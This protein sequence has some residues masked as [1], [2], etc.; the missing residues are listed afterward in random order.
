MALPFHLNGHSMDEKESRLQPFLSPPIAVLLT[1][2]GKLST[3]REKPAHSSQVIY[4]FWIGTR[5]LMAK[6]GQ[7]LLRVGAAAHDSR[8]FLDYSGFLF[9]LNYVVC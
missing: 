5:K 2:R 1:L 9:S 7:K 3:Q 4:Y 8:S 6:Q